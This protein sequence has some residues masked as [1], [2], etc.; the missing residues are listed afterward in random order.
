MSG[1]LMKSIRD[2]KDSKG[3]FRNVQKG[4]SS[5]K[6][7]FLREMADLMPFFKVMAGVVA[8]TLFTDPLRCRSLALCYGVNFSETEEGAEQET[9]LPQR[10][11]Q[12]APRLNMTEH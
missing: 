5:Q 10:D 2:N 9:C 11:V 7:V 12:E 4:Q 6:G 3:L 1:Y 8:C